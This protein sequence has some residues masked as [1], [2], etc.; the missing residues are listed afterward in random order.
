ML[1]KY[2]INGYKMKNKSILITGASGSIGFA[3][4]KKVI[5]NGYDAVMCYNKNDSFIEK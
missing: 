4:S 1:L 3:I 5:E 2:S